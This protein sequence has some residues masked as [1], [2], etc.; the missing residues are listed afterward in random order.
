MRY[1]TSR[2]LQPPPGPQQ[3]DWANPLTQGLVF[4]A[5][6]GDGGPI[7]DLVDPKR[8]SD[9]PSQG[10]RV[11]GRTVGGVSIA[12]ALTSDLNFTTHSF[13]YGAKFFITQAGVSSSI[14]ERGFW[15][16][17]QGNGGYGLFTRADGRLHLKHHDNNADSD[18]GNSLYETLSPPYPTS[19]GMA[20][21]Y[22]SGSSGR[23]TVYR[24]G[25][26]Y[27]SD[28]S[29]ARPHTAASSNLRI[30]GP[31]TPTS[32]AWLFNRAVSPDVLAALTDNPFQVLQPARQRLVFP[33]GLSGGSADVTVS[34]NGVAGAGA[35]GS[36]SLHVGTVTDVAGSV[37]D[38]AIGGVLASS[39]VMVSLAGGLA[40]LG[41]G[42]VSVPLDEP[43]TAGGGEL[44]GQAGQTLVR[45][46]CATSVVSMAM[47]GWLGTTSA[48][49]PGWGVEGPS[50]GG[51]IPTTRSA[52]GWTKAMPAVGAWVTPAVPPAG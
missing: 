45:V 27:R 49:R 31:A 17:A 6:P 9:A 35:V 36:A 51:W 2:W 22:A 37:G 14:L 28:D 41:Q 47:I 21:D 30:G 10:H 23:I 12:A 25:R 19:Y 20:F 39:S 34:A 4:F 50:G 44:A 48:R 5:C 29:F 24:N 1:L 16:Y 40:S 33:V 46:D 52:G 32:C 13:S 3:I 15:D 26:F 18:G 8:S 43:V 11:T 42:T 38:A 7:A